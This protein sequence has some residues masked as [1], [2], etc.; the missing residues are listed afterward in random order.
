MYTNKKS[1]VVRS[2]AQAGQL[3]D[4]VVVHKNEL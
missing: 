1:R 2:G 3:T 4:S